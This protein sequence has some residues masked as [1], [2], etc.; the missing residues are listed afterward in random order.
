MGKITKGNIEEV[1]AASSE[2]IELVLLRKDFSN[3]SFVRIELTSA[4]ISN[5]F[6]IHQ[7]FMAIFIQNVILS[8]A[9]LQKL[10]F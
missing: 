9:I 5:A 4:T 10:T 6:L 7:N 8:H 3:E 1:K 2:R